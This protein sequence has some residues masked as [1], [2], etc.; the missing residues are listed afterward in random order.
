MKR[1][2]VDT[3]TRNHTPG[4][5]SDLGRKSSTARDGSA[6]TSGGGWRVGGNVLVD[7]QSMSDIV[8]VKNQVQ[9][10]Q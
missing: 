7:S 3:C 9:Q 5:R 2:T 8:R 10:I 6:E 1:D 4:T